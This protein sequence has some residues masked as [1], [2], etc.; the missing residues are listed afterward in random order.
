[1]ADI[2]EIRFEAR[3]LI[4]GELVDGGA[5]LSTTR[6]GRPTGRSGSGASSSFR[7]RWR[8]SRRRSAR[9]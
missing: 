5:G 8:A 1:V 2:P 3:M 4:D 6:A 7:R 9:S